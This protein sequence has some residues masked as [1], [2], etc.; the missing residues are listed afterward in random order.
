MG[1]WNAVI[2]TTTSWQAV[3]RLFRG[4]LKGNQ[5]NSLGYNSRPTQFTR[6]WTGTESDSV[7]GLAMG[8][9]SGYAEV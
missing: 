5:K 1:F 2:Y 6:K 8:H 9:G 7:K 3:R 4:E